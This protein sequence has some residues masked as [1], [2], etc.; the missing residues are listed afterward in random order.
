MREINRE[1]D[2]K[3]YEKNKIK[4]HLSMVRH[5]KYETRLGDLS[6]WYILVNTSV[7]THDT[8]ICIGV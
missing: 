7:S 8:P 1:R 6:D 4:R 3:E 2:R 5:L